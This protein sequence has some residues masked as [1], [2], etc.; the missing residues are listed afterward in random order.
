VCFQEEKK[1]R[2][3]KRREE[4]R[5]EEKRREE[6]RRGLY[7]LDA[8]ESEKAINVA[9]NIHRIIIKF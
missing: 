6:K 5:R 2:E 8:C 1:R 3:E 7:I 9:V 4:K